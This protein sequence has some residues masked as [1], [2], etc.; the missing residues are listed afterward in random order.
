[1]IRFESYKFSPA[2]RGVE[3]N[4]DTEKPRKIREIVTAIATTLDTAPVTST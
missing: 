1:L 4:A 2:R 3:T